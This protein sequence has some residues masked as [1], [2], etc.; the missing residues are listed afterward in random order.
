M[1]NVILE[2][3]HVLIYLLTKTDFDFLMSN[4]CISDPNK[5]LRLT[6]SYLFQSVIY[7]ISSEWFIMLSLTDKFKL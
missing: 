5:F 1:I 6:N 4:V 2:L 7:D 3:N